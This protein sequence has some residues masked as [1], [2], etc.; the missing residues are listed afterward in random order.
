MRF[1]KI[2]ALD[3]D[4]SAGRASTAIAGGSASRR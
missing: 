1:G 4:S 2:Y 3:G